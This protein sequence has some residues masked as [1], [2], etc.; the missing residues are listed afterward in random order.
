MNFIK[1]LWVTLLRVLIVGSI[2]W[3]GYSQTNLQELQN[4]VTE[5]EAKLADAK[6]RQEKAYKV[7]MQ[8][9]EQEQA[10]AKLE[11]SE[12]YKVKVIEIRSD[13]QNVRT[14]IESIIKEKNDLEENLRIARNLQ[15]ILH[16]AQGHEKITVKTPSNMNQLSSTQKALGS[17][18]AGKV[19]VTSESDKK[20]VGW[21]I[22]SIRFDDQF[23]YGERKEIASVF[24]VNHYLNQDDI[25]NSA[26]QIYKNTGIIMHFKVHLKAGDSAN[27]D[28]LLNQ[29]EPRNSNYDSNSSFPFFSK[30]KPLSEF[31]KDYF[32]ITISND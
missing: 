6:A 9:E 14:R 19:S 3:P 24:I 17:T 8:L 26:Y 12:R 25:L 30:I 32:K 23:N 29:R 7:Q 21:Q 4:Q 11:V 18:V 22:K 20:L 31:K 13:I 27:F 5:L 10:L 16:D 1:P 2:A 28:I 15:G